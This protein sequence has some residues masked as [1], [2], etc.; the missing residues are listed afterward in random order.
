MEIFHQ[1]I[2]LIQRQESTGNNFHFLNL[3]VPKEKLNLVVM[4]P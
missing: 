2:P 4:P 1:V 3:D